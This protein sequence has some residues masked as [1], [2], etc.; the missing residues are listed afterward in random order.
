[1]PCVD[2]LSLLPA[3]RR[4]AWRL[5]ARLPASVDHDDLVQAGMLGI[6]EAAGRAEGESSAAFLM[7][8]A[9]GAMLDYLRSMDYLT[10][11]ERRKVRALDRARDRV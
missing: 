11:H 4:S 10:I 7:L 1:M 2:P 3:I 6:L 8:R 5:H 9:R